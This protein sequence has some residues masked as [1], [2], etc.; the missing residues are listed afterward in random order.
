MKG[1]VPDRA[2]GDAGS[3]PRASVVQ[4]ICLCFLFEIC[5]PDSLKVN[6]VLPNN[7]LVGDN[8]NST[9]KY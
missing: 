5:S 6:R 2:V 1:R 7:G 9:S 3:V 4:K 8:T